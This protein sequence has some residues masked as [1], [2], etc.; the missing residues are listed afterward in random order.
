MPASSDVTLSVS[1]GPSTS[2]DRRFGA[3]TRL[4]L[5]PERIAEA[6]VFREILKPLTRGLGPVGEIAVES[7]ADALF[8]RDVR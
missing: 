2:P 5:T 7:V 3:E 8:L 4:R 1:K 6:V